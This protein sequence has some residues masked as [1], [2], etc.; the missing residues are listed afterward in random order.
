MNVLWLAAAWLTASAAFPQQSGEVV[1]GDLQVRVGLSGT[2]VATETFRIKSAIAGRVEAILPSTGSWAGPDE[3]LGELAS[4]EMS[5][6]LDS[7]Q[8]A[9]GRSMVEERWKPVYKPEKIAC[10][11][12]CFVLKTFVK[13]KQWVRPKAVLVEAARKLRLVGRVRPE[14]A[15]WVENGQAL[16]F[17]ASSDPSRKFKATVAGFEL[18]APA[19]QAPSGGTMAIDM[20]PSRFLPP[21]TQWEGLVVPLLRRKALVVPTAA[22]IVHQG[23]SYLPVR[24]STGITT[25]AETEL[26]GGA[27]EGTPILILEEGRLEGAKRH[28]PGAAPG[29]GENREPAAPEAEAKPEKGGAFPEPGIDY[30]AE[31]YAP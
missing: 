29:R 26:T 24:V 14:D 15:R 7:R 28:A 30:G 11:E 16:E 25:E 3:S 17:W 27:A 12:E 19:S 10:P 4:K 21:G 1:R 6:L 18:D 22:L 2:V 20:S 13:P 8:A 9:P 23:E 31:P 5:A